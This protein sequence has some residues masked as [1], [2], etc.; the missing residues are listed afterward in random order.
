MKRSAAA[1]FLFIITST[2]IAGSPINEASRGAGQ[3]LGN[4]G[5]GVGDAIGDSMQESIKRNTPH[6]ITIAPRTKEDCFKETGGIVN[7]TFMRCR[8]GYQQS[9]Y[10]LSTGEIRVLQERPI[11]AN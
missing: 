7:K 6:W 10:T 8:N 5:A 4:F 9:V 2:A 3:A 11:P 1:F